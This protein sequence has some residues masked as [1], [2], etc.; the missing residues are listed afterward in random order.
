MNIV[1]S[2]TNKGHNVKKE[3][4]AEDRKGSTRPC[5]TEQQY[6]RGVSSI[7]VIE[8]RGLLRANIVDLSRGRIFHVARN[9]CLS[10]ANRTMKRVVN[11]K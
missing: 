5:R 1:T 7:T 2:T 4:S 9:F 3:G 10:V 8:R 6:L 11:P